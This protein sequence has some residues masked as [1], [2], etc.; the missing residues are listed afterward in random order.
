MPAS[1]ADRFSIFGYLRHYAVTTH[2]R[3]AIARIVADADMLML[4]D[5]FD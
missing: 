5:A 2:R 4:F 3:Y 1:A